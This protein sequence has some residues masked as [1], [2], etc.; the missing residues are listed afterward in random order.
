MKF[1]FRQGDPEAPVLV[2]LHGTGGDEHSLLEVGHRLN[3]G[4]S[5]L[6]V[7][8]NILENGLPRYF[9]RLAEG[10]YDEEDLNIQGK[11]LAQFI[12]EIAAEKGFSLAQVFLIGY[13]NGANIALHLLLTFSNLFRKGIL[14]HPMYPIA[15]LPKNSLAR[16]KI[17]MSFGKNDPIVSIEESN[18][19]QEI[20][21]TRGAQTCYFWTP[22]HRLTHGEVEASREWLRAL[23]ES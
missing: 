13:S 21:E 23:D 15:Q 16:L 19:V 4:A 2:L 22:S 12:Q 17:F 6:G 9:K 8:G 10:V 5:L 7:R 20:V 14:Y 3:P 18:Y 1:I 11:K